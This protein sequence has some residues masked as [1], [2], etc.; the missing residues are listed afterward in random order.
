MGRTAPQLRA[1]ELGE[2]LV[3]GEYFGAVVQGGDEQV[4]MRQF[5]EQ[6]TC[7]LA[8]ADRIA[9]GPF[10]AF[11]DGRAKEEVLHVGG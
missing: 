3:I 9:D 5:V 2:Q 11:Q 10:D 4:L 8:V 7:V 1:E 6:P